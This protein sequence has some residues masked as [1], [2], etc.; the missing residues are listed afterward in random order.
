[1]RE[2]G[3]LPRLPDL[4]LSQP[5][6]GVNLECLDV[7]TGTRVRGAARKLLPAL[8]A[9][10]GARASAHDDRSHTGQ[11]RQIY[12][13]FTEFTGETRPGGL[14]W[15]PTHLKHSSSHR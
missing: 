2:S 4:S 8:R 14:W 9:A 5:S 12:S 6:L 10:G 11:Q 7:R 1:M 15:T 13:L 3:A